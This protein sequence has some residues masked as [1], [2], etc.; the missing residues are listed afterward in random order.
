M[1][2]GERARA[3]SGTSLTSLCPPC[4]CGRSLAP[5]GRRGLGRTA[6]SRLTA[7]LHQTKVQ[8][9]TEGGLA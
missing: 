4:R 7:G 8:V 9:Q 3:E 2:T 6:A 5:V 1:G